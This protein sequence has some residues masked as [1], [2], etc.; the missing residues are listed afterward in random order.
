MIMQSSSKAF[1]PILQ[2]IGISTCF[3]GTFP[4][5]DDLNAYS[6]ILIN[7]YG[8]SIFVNYEHP[9]KHSFPIDITPSGIVIVEIFVYENAYSPILFNV[10]G[11]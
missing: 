4:K 10:D 6:P 3:R 1:I 8:N 5:N 9:L 2:F 11:N 7:D